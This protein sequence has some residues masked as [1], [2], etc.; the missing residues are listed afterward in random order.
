M[1][2]GSRAARLAPWTLTVLLA[3]CLPFQETG[4]DEDDLL[5]VSPYL[6]AILKLPDGYDTTRTYPLLV[7]LHGYGGTAGGFASGFEPV[8]RAGYFVAIPEAR[9]ATANGGYSWFYRTSDRTLWEAY[10]TMSVRGVVAL[11]E[12]LRDRYPIGDVYLLGFSEGVSLVYM[13]GFRNPAL[14]TGMVAIAGVLPDIDTLGAIVR[15]ADVDSARTIRVFVARGTSDGLVSRQSY[16]RQT[17]LLTTH[18]YPVTSWEF[19]GGHYLSD[20]VVERVID[21]LREATAR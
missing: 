21:W 1:Q 5:F 15:T 18:G 6:A 4:P 11:V 10:D 20:E 16:L 3:A 17:E 9:F 7:T 14:V 19:G 12:A 13:T 2:P 8:S